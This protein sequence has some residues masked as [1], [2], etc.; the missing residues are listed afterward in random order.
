[1]PIQFGNPNGQDDLRQILAL[2][3]ENLPVN[4]SAVEL[5]EQ[6]FVTVQHNEPLL[7]DMNAAEPQVIA[8]DGDRVVGYAL[9]MLREFS[10]RIPVLIPMF[11]MLESLSYKGRKLLESRYYVVGQVCVAKSHRGQ[12]VFDGLYE[13]HR[14]QMSDRYDCVLTEIA[15]RNRRSLRAHWR[16]GFETIHQYTGPDGEGW[17]IVFWGWTGDGRH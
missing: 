14:R 5:E 7:T 15:T 8:K 12:G 16:V 17:D 6:G 10:S 9:V 1:M 3:R 2:Q 13:Q 11:E 4:I